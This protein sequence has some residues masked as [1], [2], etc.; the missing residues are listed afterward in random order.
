MKYKNQIVPACL[1]SSV[2]LLQSSNSLV[3]V[4]RKIGASIT[5][6]VCCKCIYISEVHATEGLKQSCLLLAY[7][8]KAGAEQL[9]AVP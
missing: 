6:H 5:K 2:C 4:R 7:L 9:L 1:A 3:R 8:Q